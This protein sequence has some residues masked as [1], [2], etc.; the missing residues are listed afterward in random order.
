MSSQ[1]VTLANAAWTRRAATAARGVPGRR[2]RYLEFL[3]A[4]G[5]GRTARRVWSS[6]L[7]GGD[8]VNL[9]FNGGFENEHLLGWGLDWRV[10]RVWAWRSPSTASSPL[11]D[12]IRCD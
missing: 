3:L 8:D 11:A 4:E 5:D 9:V 12:A 10:N 7:P 1:D 2:P 6:L